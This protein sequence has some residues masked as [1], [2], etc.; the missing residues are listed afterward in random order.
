MSTVP[1]RTGHENWPLRLTT[2]RSASA[3]RE[4]CCPAPALSTLLPRDGGSDAA[5]APGRGKENPLS[6]AAPAS[7]APASPATAPAPAPQR[8]ASA[9]GTETVLWSAASYSSSSPLVLLARSMSSTAWRTLSTSSF[10]RAPRSPW[11]SS[12]PKGKPCRYTPHSSSSR[13]SISAMLHRSRLSA[14]AAPGPPLAPAL[15]PALPST[16]KSTRTGRRSRSSRKRRRRAA[17][18]ST[19][20]CPGSR[21]ATQCTSVGRTEQYESHSLGVNMLLIQYRRSSLST[22]PS[23]H[24]PRQRRKGDEGSKDASAASPSPSPPP[25]PAASSASPA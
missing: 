5:S 11:K 23:V 25:P 19:A 21:R 12:W 17:A 9:S 13:V 14:G 8:S 15:A 10:L 4:P 7:P 3:S 18:L 20:A 22:P 6:A 24:T 1:V 2:R 16:P